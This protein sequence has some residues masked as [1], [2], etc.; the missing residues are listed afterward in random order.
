MVKHIITEYLKYNETP[1]VIST[2]SRSI[3]T[4]PTI[5]Y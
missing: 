3:K 4:R 5:K 1:H 2:D